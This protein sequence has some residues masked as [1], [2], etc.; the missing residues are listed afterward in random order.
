VSSRAKYKRAASRA[1]SRI[2]GK[3]ADIL[4][5]DD[6]M[7]PEEKITGRANCPEADTCTDTDCYHC[8]KAEK[9]KKQE[10]PKEPE[11]E[12]MYSFVARGTLPLRLAKLES[13][14]YPSAVKK[15]EWRNNDRCYHV[16]LAVSA[17]SIETMREEQ[18]AEEAK[19]KIITPAEAGVTLLVG[20]DGRPL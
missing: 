19:K 2:K 7:K 17:K 16:T 14:H 18:E 12:V 15:I 8:P 6:P 20:P 1:D 4:I 9:P 5:L 10:K 11:V 3:K 13:G